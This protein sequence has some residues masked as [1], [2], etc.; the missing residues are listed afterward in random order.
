MGALAAPVKEVTNSML[1][2]VLAAIKAL[3]FARD[4]GF[5][6]IVLEGDSKILVNRLLYSIQD[7]SGVG[8]LVEEARL[9]SRQ[10]RRITWA[11]MGC[12]PS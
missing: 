6:D 3:E 10:G 4:M 12:S 8:V 5:H 11:S 1:V 7:I 9:L 2:K